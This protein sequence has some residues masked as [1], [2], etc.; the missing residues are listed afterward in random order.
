M[1]KEIIQENIFDEHK[2]VIQEDRRS[3]GEHL[4]H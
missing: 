2:I 3:Q 1:V 4:R